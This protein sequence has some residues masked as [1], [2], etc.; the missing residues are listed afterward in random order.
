MAYTMTSFSGVPLPD[1]NAILD[2][3][4]PEAHLSIVPTI[5]GNYDYFGY[6]Q[7]TF[8]KPHTF[9]ISGIYNDQTYTDGTIYDHDGN[10]I[11]TSTADELIELLEDLKAKVG[12]VGPLIRHVLDTAG[13][14]ERKFCRLLQV[15]YVT[16]SKDRGI[17]AP[18]TAIFS[19]LQPH[20]Q[21]TTQ[22]TETDTLSAGANSTSI[23]PGG[24]APIYDAVIT[25]TATGTITNVDIQLDN[26]HL[27]FSGTLTNTQVLVIDCG[28]YS[29]TK[30]GSSAYSTFAL[31]GNHADNVWIRMLPNVANS[32]DITLTGAGAS[33]SV[34]YY[35]QYF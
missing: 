32:L 4:T 28:N 34:A 33:L 23:T 27:V 20:W 3:S 13:R 31:G 16:R 12:T 22:T 6:D 7:R 26:T 9:Q 24:T 25:L 19:T 2:A 1:Y 8:I 30:Q 35:D 29:V 18:T 17:I 14:T 10:S 15:E 5:S 21:D 11:T